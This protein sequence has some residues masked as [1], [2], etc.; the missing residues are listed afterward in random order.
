MAT[1]DG[2]Q[3]R[4]ILTIIGGDDSTSAAELSGD[5][6]RMT[7]LLTGGGASWSCWRG[8]LPGLAALDDK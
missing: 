2:R 5:F 3:E 1:G 6:E 7:H 8:I 4:G